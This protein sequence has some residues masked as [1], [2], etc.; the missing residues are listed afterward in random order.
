MSEN[1]I[2]NEE[3]QIEQLALRLLVYPGDPR[4]NKPRLFLGTIPDTLPVAI[5][6]PEKSRALGTLARSEEQVEIVLESELKPEEIVAFYRA[7][8]KETGW[9]EL[10]D[11]MMLPHTGGF[12]HG[13]FSP[14]SH[15]TFCQG[16]DGASL[17]LS[18]MQFEARGA[19]IRL[20]LNLGRE[21]NPCARQEKPR[22]QMH[23]HGIYDIIPMLVP[24]HG[25]QQHS[26]SGGSSDNEAYTT[27]TLKTDLELDAVAKH[28]ATQLLQA[29]WTQTAEDISGPVAWCTW[30]FTDEEQE[31]WTG[32]FFI[33]KTPE[34]QNEY[35]LYIKVEWV[36]PERTNKHSGWTSTGYSSMTLHSE[37]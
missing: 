5:P 22:R 18:I 7:R 8:L 3:N 10:E 35:F 23:R 25:M 9:N 19:D 2:S 27:A 13:N 11:D 26:G 20:H 6:L 24:P 33:L 21:G 32:L 17:M 1:P 30:K 29:G 16:P 4:T 31:P 34:K 12:L 14:H 36:R 28:Y 37:S 15:I